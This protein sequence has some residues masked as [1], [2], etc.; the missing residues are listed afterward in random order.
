GLAIAY[1]LII[2]PHYAMKHQGD[3]LDSPSRSPSLNINQRLTLWERSYKMGTVIPALGL[4]CSALWG[5]L[6]AMNRNKLAALTPNWRLLGIGAAAQF[7]IVP[8]TLIVIMPVNTK[9]MA[10]RKEANK[11]E[12]VNEAEV[13]QLFQQWQKL[14]LV[15]CGFLAVGLVS[16]IGAFVW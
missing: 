13:E 14:H 5:S 16:A 3:L 12:S 9:L 11:R 1:P 15:R 2:N 10:L 8:W 4:A 6:Y 7:S